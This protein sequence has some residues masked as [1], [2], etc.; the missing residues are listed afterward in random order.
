MRAYLKR[1]YGAGNK[2]DRLDA[3]LLMRSLLGWLRGESK[4]CSRAPIPTIAEEDARRPHRE[5]QTLVKEQTR[6][7]NRIKSTLN[8]LSREARTHAPTAYNRPGSRRYGLRRLQPFATM[9]DSFLNVSPRNV[10]AAYTIATA[11]S[12]QATLLQATPPGLPLAP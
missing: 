9:T 7:V 10:F 8:L 6:V 5:H 12:P 3:G 4:H 2:T 11:S 1:S